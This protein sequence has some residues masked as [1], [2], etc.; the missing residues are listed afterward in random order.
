MQ[1]AVLPPCSAAVTPSGRQ[2]QAETA[3]VMADRDLQR[4]L[5][6]QSAAGWKTEAQSRTTVAGENVDKRSVGSPPST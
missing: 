6:P 3:D 4:D 1:R 2:R 5:F